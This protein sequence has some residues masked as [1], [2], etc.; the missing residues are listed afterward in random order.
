MSIA[1]DVTIENA[2]GGSGHDDIIGNHT[3]NILTGNGGSDQLWGNGAIIL[4][5]MPVPEIQ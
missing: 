4:S 1:A 5:A 3:N 2:I